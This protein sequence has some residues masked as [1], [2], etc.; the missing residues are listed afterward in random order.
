MFLATP[1]VS[2]VITAS[3]TSLVQ[4]ETVAANAVEVIS[5][6]EEAPHVT[7]CLIDSDVEIGTTV[8]LEAVIGGDLYKALI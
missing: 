4:T 3:E 2:E 5:Q 6:R 7:T 8:T 1:N